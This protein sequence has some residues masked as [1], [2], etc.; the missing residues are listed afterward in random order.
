MTTGDWVVTAPA[1]RAGKGAGSAADLW[2]QARNMVDFGR[3]GTGLR[4]G[5]RALGHL[6]NE[7]LPVGEE[8]VLRSRI[9]VTMADAQVELGRTP[10]RPTILLDAAAAAEPDGVA[11][12]A[13]VPRGAAGQD[14][15]TAGGP[16]QLDAGVGALSQS[17]RPSANLVRALL[18]RGLLHLSEARLERR[19]RIARWAPIGPIAGMDPAVAVATHNL[20]LVRYVS[21]DLPGALHEMARRRRGAPMCGPAFEPSTGP[22]CCAMPGCWR[23]RGSTPIGRNGFS[24]AERAQVD[25]AT[26]C[27][28]RRRSTSW[29]G[30]Q[31][32]R[33]AAARRAARNYAP[34]A[35][36]GACWRPG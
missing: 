27:W 35:T 22:G 8:A 26:R 9:L 31:G 12:G 16:E 20:G 36:S 3:P 6:R 32:R 11:D 21:G 19:R 28:S 34:P 1:I 5:A 4:L 33:G 24:P 29:P 7:H 15:S 30:G 2:A 10:P 14:R 18:W 23:R 13:G 25:L 17:G